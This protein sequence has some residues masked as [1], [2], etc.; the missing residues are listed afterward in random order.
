[1]ATPVRKRHEP[2]VSPDTLT[3]E[4]QPENKKAKTS[5]SENGN[6]A[7]QAVTPKQA[8]QEPSWSEAEEG[9]HTAGKRRVPVG[10]TQRQAQ[11]FEISRSQKS[12]FVFNPFGFECWGPHCQ[13]TIC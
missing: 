1:M 7:P 3:A 11:W 5:G 6:D 12:K 10:M 9:V 2:P 4:S 8:P 13:G